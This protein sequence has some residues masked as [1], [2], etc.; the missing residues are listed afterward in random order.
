MD[1]LFQACAV[2]LC[3]YK[4]ANEKRNVSFKQSTP[5]L[6]VTQSFLLFKK[7]KK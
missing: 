4:D 3:R 7:I 6:K 2:I 1:N 5:H